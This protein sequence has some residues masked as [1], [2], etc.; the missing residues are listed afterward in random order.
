M[1]KLSASLQEANALL[2]ILSHLQKIDPEF[3]LQY[4]ICLTE[5]SLEEGLSV[6]TLADK[7]GLALSTVSRIIGALSQY[8]QNGQPYGLVEIRIPPEE[9]RRKELYLTAK[10]RS[11]LQRIY[12]SL[13]QYRN[14]AAA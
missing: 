4:M 11:L 8:R 3:P 5:I 13:G 7:T 1:E 2:D 12:K 6:T 14:S 10:G 9:R